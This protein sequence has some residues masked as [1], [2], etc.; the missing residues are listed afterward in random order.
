MASRWSWLVRVVGSGGSFL[1]FI[2]CVSSWWVIFLFVPFHIFRKGRW[3]M[4]GSPM[5]WAIS[6]IFL[7]VSWFAPT[8]LAMR[9]ATAPFPP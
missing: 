1:V 7:P 3:G 9:C 2:S 4:V 8:F 5:C 6:M